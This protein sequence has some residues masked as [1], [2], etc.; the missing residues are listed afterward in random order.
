M[1]ADAV[2]SWQTL[3]QHFGTD[4]SELLV[5]FIAKEIDDVQFMREDIALWKAV[6]PRIHKD[7]LFR[8]Y[9]GV[10]L[11]QGARQV[12]TRLRNNGVMVVI[13]S[14][15]IDIFVSIIA[16]M[17]K[18]D[19]WIANGFLFDDDGWLEDEGVLRISAH[20][21]ASSVLRIMQMHG[22]SA[23]E[24]VCVG[25]SEVDLSMHVEGAAFIAFNPSRE[26][27]LAAFQQARVPLVES[28]DLRDIW[29]H[30]FAEQFHANA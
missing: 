13:I 17:L 29:I 16:N 20:D 3:H 10:R 4:S 9:S 26:T 22:F 11:M 1:L 2:S 27:S 5:R 15:G 6:Q 23:D 18:V 25:D 19:D 30:L 24:I 14:A 21:K 8:A 12:V 28:R 7:E